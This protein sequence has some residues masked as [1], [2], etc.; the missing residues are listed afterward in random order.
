VRDV[1]V[2]ERRGACFLDKTVQPL[3]IACHRRRQDLQPYVAIEL[4]V[5]G[6]LPSPIFER[7]S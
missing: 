4:R 1:R 7:I 6:I 5:T 2:K 3:L